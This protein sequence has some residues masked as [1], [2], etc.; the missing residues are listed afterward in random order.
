[1]SFT[2]AIRRDMAAD[3]A[4]AMEVLNI[5]VPLCY[6]ISQGGMWLLNG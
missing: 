2:G 5:P 1:M 3:V 4:E 6:G